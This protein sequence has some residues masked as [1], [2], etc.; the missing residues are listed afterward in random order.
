MK[1]NF[2]KDYINEINSAAPD[3]DLLWQK[4]AASGSADEDIT[5]FESAAEETV[6]ARPNIKAFVYRSL[7]SVAAVFVAVF[8]LSLA[9]GKGGS[10]SL[11]DNTENAALVEPALPE[12]A[13]NDESADDDPYDHSG[14]VMVSAGMGWD[15]AAGIMNSAADNYDLLT[16]A[17]SD[18][19]LYTGISSDN[20]DEEYFVEETVLAETDYFVDGKIISSEILDD[21]IVYTMEVIHLVSDAQIFVSDQFTAISRSPYALRENREY[22]LP[23]KEE[24]GEAYIVFDNAPQ[25]EIAEDRTVICH[26]GWR[27]LTENCTYITYPQIYED[28]YFYDRMN[29]TAEISLERLFESWEKLRL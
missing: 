28:D 16:L 14:M 21:R 20:G 29:I 9:F 2:E 4:I 8:C 10:A 15:F 24:N 11:S 1:R 19:P 23:I 27:S 5:P 17:Y 26:N 13:S 7:G 3:M 18:S 25:I 12:Y 6:K 22:L